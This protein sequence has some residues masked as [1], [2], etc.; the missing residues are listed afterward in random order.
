MFYS[1][2]VW[3]LNKAV[4]QVFLCTDLWKDAAVLKSAYD[5]PHGVTAAFITNGMR[6]VQR[7]LAEVDE[8]PPSNKQAGRWAY[9]CL[10]NADAKQV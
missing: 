9:D 2:V 10:V 4:W 5:D 8:S 7:V 6:H 3:C 1:P